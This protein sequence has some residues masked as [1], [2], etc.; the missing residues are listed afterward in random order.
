VAFAMKNGSHVMCSI[1]C[2]NDKGETSYADKYVG[3]GAYANSTTSIK[4]N[5]DCFILSCCNKDMVDNLTMWRLYGNDG[6]G[7]CLEYDVDITKI[8]GKEFFFIHISILST[9]K[10]PL[11][12]QKS[13]FLVNY[14]C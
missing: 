6:K 5:N 1:T 10:L 11:F 2:M 8:D 12:F 3:Y 14:L 7:V 13:N 4:E 9:A